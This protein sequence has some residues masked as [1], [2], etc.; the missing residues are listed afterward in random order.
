[1][2]RDQKLVL[3]NALKNEGK[4]ALDIDGNA[5]KVGDKVTVEKKA[6]FP[7]HIANGWV[8]H[9]EK[10]IG[11]TLTINEINL[12][13]I[14]FESLSTVDTDHGGYG[15]PPN[16]L[17]KVAVLKEGAKVRITKKLEEW[18]SNRWVAD[19]DEVLDGRI[20]TVIRE[21]RLKNG[22]WLIQITATKGH[23]S[24]YWFPES[25]IEVVEALPVDCSGRVIIYDASGEEVRNLAVSDIHK[26]LSA[27]E[28]VR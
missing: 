24:S 11:K 23:K 10:A 19:M 21:P 28:A 22:D 6:E 7:E 2:T 13:G 25:I 26:A 12:N 20:C 3:F 4:E 5:L 14:Y 1:M 16:A 27:V 15:F 9:M 18:D 17:R 8:P